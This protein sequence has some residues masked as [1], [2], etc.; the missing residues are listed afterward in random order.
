MSSPLEL[1]QNMMLTPTRSILTGYASWLCA[2]GMR[3]RSFKTAQMV[4]FLL[5]SLFQPSRSLWS[6]HLCSMVP[7][8]ARQ[9]SP[10]LK[11]HPSHGLCHVFFQS[12]LIFE[13]CVVREGGCQSLRMMQNWIRADK[14]ILL[15]RP[16]STRRSGTHR[17]RQTVNNNRNH[18]NNAHTET[19]NGLAGARALTLMTPNTSQVECF[20]FN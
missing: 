5:N 19:E 13:I 9:A 17:L 15:F 11:I 16:N 8:H 20:I 12:L 3:L 10:L 7:Q 14:H 2:S 18:N 1:H 6:S 4:S